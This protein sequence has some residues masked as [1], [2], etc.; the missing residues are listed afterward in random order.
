MIPQ[1]SKK[2]KYY[3]A[4]EN[5]INLEIGKVA[6]EKPVTLNLNGKD[7]LTFL[8]TPSDLK[9]LAIG[10]LYNESLIQAISKI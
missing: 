4:K 8:C 1:Q 3:F 5:Q 6:F 7:W 9:A 2:I 10:F